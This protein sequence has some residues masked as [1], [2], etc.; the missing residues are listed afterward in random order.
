MKWLLTHLDEKV[1]LE[2]FEHHP[3]CIHTALH[4]SWARSANKTETTAY[5]HP[6]QPLQ[7]GVLLSSSECWEAGHRG[8]NKEKTL[9]RLLVGDGVSENCVKWVIAVWL[10]SD[11]IYTCF[12]CHLWVCFGAQS[13]QLLGT[14]LLWSWMK[15][16]M[17]RFL[18]PSYDWMASNHCLLEV[19]TT[20]Y[21]S[22]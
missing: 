2:L 1:K 18:A 8:G 15:W 22:R 9:R 5:G 6:V 4:R 16:V 12:W 11:I 19:S 3:Y 14:F 10:L 7:L 21:N 20:Y 13:Q 17:H